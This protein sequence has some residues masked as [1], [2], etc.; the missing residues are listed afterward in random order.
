MVPY[1]YI[2]PSEIWSTEEEGGLLSVHNST[3]KPPWLDVEWK[4]SW[5]FS[6]PSVPEQDQ[7]MPKY[8]LSAVSVVVSIDLM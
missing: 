5:Y 3:S 4:L 8:L 2:A 6:K 7:C 1:K